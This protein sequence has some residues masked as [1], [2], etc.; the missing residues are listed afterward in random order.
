M[1]R[2]ARV[3]R[4][5]T[6]AFRT[7]SNLALRS[8]AP[9]A[10]LLPLAALAFVATAASTAM[11]API[12]SS[13]AKRAEELYNTPTYDRRDLLS[14]LQAQAH[15]DPR[16]A[17]VLWR[18]ARA[19]YDVAGL[20]STA[21]AE[22]KELTYLAH[23]TIQKA[24]ALADDDFAV[25]KWSGIILSSIGD[26]EGTKVSLSNSFIVK[27]HWEKAIALN[28]RDATSHHLLGRWSLTIADISWIERK[29]AAALFGTPPQATY[30]EALAHFLDADTIS[31]G[32][33]K[34]NTYMIAL[35]QHKMGH[36]DEAKAWVV[37]ALAI[38]STSEEDAQ[39]H[40]DA[41]ALQ[42]KLG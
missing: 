34:K 1:H 41:L 17:G 13:R 36:A 16:D 22:K 33:W 19:A 20:G 38:P 37:K 27:A 23:E 29:V 30:A 39:V 32:F 9:A 2:L 10:R 25:Q 21:A 12:E 15:E 14:H 31:P 24:L 3:A 11:S 28:P 8:S 5:V 6:P 42:A 35:V 26:Y 7:A 40:Q 4:A 18:L